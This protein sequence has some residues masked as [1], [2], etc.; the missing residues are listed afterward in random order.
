[1]NDGFP[2]AEKAPGS[3]IRTVV[4][5]LA[6]T[7]LGAGMLGLPSAFA[8]CGLVIG[9]LMLVLFAMS[10]SY[11]LHLLSE[12][13]NRVGRPASFHKLCDA[14]STHAPGSESQV[15]LPL[16]PTA[17]PVSQCQASASS[18]TARSPSSALAW[19]RPTSSSSATICRMPY[20]PFS[21]SILVNICAEEPG[22]SADCGLSWPFA[23]ALRSLS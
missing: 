12:C 23:S 19:P 4:F 17:L 10:A 11:S 18:S 15:P 22:R 16:L 3:P 8:S 21:T 14:A 2:E 1:M 7:I 20:R 13:A 9:Y 6:N 5:V